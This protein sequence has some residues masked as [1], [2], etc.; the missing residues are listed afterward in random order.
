MMAAQVR[1]TNCVYHGGVRIRELSDLW[2]IALSK[3]TQRTVEVTI[4]T[5]SIIPTPRTRCAHIVHTVQIVVAS[6]RRSVDFFVSVAPDFL[7][8]SILCLGRWSQSHS[9]QFSLRRREASWRTPSNN[10]AVYQRLSTTHRCH[11]ARMLFFRSVSVRKLSVERISWWGLGSLLAD[12]SL[13]V[14]WAYIKYFI[15][16]IHSFDFTLILRISFYLLGFTERI[17]SYGFEL[18]VWTQKQC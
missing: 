4:P 16:S 7:S 18:K 14:H 11:D 12:S 1:N 17:S 8:Y 15:M 6:L 9:S 13:F 10:N 5:H 3:K 2:N